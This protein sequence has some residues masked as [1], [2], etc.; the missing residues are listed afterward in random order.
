MYPQRC[1]DDRPHG[2]HP[3]P[4]SGTQTGFTCA[5]RLTEAEIEAEFQ[6]LFLE[7]FSP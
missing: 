4:P 3:V 2:P 1:S 6:R 7:E 5:G